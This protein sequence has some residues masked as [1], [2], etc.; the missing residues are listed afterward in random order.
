MVPL[1]KKLHRFRYTLVNKQK[2]IFSADQVELVAR[3]MPT[4]ADALRTKCGLIDTQIKA[5]GEQ[6]LGITRAHER[7]Q[8]KFE[9][10]VAEINA[11][12]RGGMAAMQILNKVYKRIIAHFGMD[13][14][15]Y[16]VLKAAGV[17]VDAD[18]GK[19]IRRKVCRKLDEEEEGV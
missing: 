13:A 12:V 17:Y 19:L 8:E 7:D 1:S 18:T 16:D 4:D 5:Y 15:M 10:C 11:F 2:M 6:L 3:Y 9:D 14:E